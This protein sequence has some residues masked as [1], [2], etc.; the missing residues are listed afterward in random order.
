MSVTPSPSGRAS[1]VLVLLHVVELDP[2]QTVLVEKDAKSSK[3]LFGRKEGP[4][5][6]CTAASSGG[7][8]G[9]ASLPG[10]W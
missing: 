6:V 10:A 5:W 8:R 4:F 7:Q 9:V 1:V 2:P 3:S